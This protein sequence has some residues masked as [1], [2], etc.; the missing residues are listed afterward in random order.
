MAQLKR[1]PQGRRRR[2]A[3]LKSQRFA[4]LEAAYRQQMRAL[5][6]L[7]RSNRSKEAKSRGNKV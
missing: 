3:D 7:L 1:A 2:A 4:E 5:R 6:D